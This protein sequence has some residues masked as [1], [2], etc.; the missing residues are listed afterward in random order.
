M[1]P[2]R[3]GMPLDRGVSFYAAE[4][5]LQ[6]SQPSQV[7]SLIIRKCVL[8]ITNLRHS[9]ARY[10]KPIPSHL[11]AHLGDPAIVRG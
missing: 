9:L 4:A 6:R 7:A 1:R 5:F 2:R 10:R 11:N 3:S 8:T